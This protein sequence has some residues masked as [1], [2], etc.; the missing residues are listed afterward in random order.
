MV[1]VIVPVYNVEKYLDECVSSLIG[2]TLQDLEII[3]VDDGSTDTS[4]TKCDIWA[5]KDSRITVYH[6]PN[7][8][9]MSAWK[10]GVERSSGDYIGF[11]D[12][13]DW[14]DADMYERM[15][16][17][18]SETGAEMVC[19]SFV[20]EYEDG[21]QEFKKDYLEAGF[22]CRERILC[23]MSPYLLIS[24][25]YHDR[26]L[27]PSKAIKMFKRELLL[28]VLQDCDDRLTIGEDLITIFSC[29]Q[30]AKGIFIMGDFYPYHYR[31]VGS[32]MMRSFSVSRYEKIDLLNQALL[33][34]NE[35][36]H[37]YDYRTQIYTDY[38]ALYF[39]TM[40]TQIL[41]TQGA[42]LIRSLRETF[43]AGSIQ[44]AISRADQMML[45]RKH[46][47]YLLLMKL[48]LIRAVVLMRRIKDR[49]S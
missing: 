6:K 48:G 20:C 11:V 46:R 27:F 26:G 24:S 10:Y 3:L 28:S 35:K 32:S 25:R 41:S 34:V 40:E 47:L 37:T 22:Y 8:G 4:G 38:L 36:Y 30:I 5:E 12:S 23:E 19:A 29:I 43:S 7:G 14:V 1:S 9:L 21:R 33:S 17:A 39:R 2:Q 18:A 31:I 49:M 15:L 16:S 44:E 42:A 45:S 13:D